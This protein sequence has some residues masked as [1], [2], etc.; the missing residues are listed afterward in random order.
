M[1]S[2]LGVLLGL[3]IAEGLLWI[4]GYRPYHRVDYQM[5]SSPQPF[6]QPHATLGLALNPGSFKVTVGQ[7]EGVSFLVSHTANGQ[8]VTGAIPRDSAAY[9]VGLFGCSYAY[10]LGIND[11]ESMGWLLQERFD[12][13]EVRN[14]CTPGYGDIQGVDLLRELSLQGDMPDIAVFNFCDFHM[15]RNT[16]SPDYRKHLMLGYER[17]K[18]GLDTIMRVS[19]FPYAVIKGG[20]LVHETQDWANM[21]RNWLGREY[22]VLINLLQTSRD[23]LFENSDKEHVTLELFKEAKALCKQHHT[24]L[25][26]SGMTD[27]EQTT[28]FLDNCKEQGI[29]VLNESIDLKD[30]LFNNHPFDTHPNGRAHRHF[31]KQL[32]NYLQKNLIAHKH[33]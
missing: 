2:V 11:R 17:S 7:D 8:R 23:R 18:S 30:T 31:A 3:V 5:N 32:G 14:F 15:E 1:T 24:R 28:V 9:S 16:L 10:G 21:Y 19:N 33:D 12:Q 13:I 27:T 6:L 4:L 29:P 26:V 22:S 20:R 25:L